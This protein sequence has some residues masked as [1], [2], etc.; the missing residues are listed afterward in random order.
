MQAIRLYT[1]VLAK[2]D[3]KRMTDQLLLIDKEED[4]DFGKLKNFNFKEL[5]RFDDV[6]AK[7]Y[8]IAG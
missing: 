6:L 2:I 8:K 1:Q 7:A 3:I 5:G 4:W